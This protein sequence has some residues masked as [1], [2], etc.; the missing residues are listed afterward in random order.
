MKRFTLICIS[1][2]LSLGLL[3]AQTKVVVKKKV[4]SG[5]EHEKVI[6][7]MHEGDMP[8]STENVF[9]IRKAM[10]SYAPVARII[11]KESGFLKKK[12]IVIDF[13]PMSKTITAVRDNGE[14][15]SEA[16]FHKYQEY[17]EDTIELP[18]LEAIEPRMKELEMRISA[19]DGMD[20]VHLVEIEALLEDLEGLDSELALMKKHQLR[21]AKHVIEMDKISE[22]IANLL[23]AE[24]ATPPQKIRE[25]KIEKGK[26]YLNGEEIPGE[27]GEKCIQAFQFQT[28]S[29]METETEGGMQ[30]IDDDMNIHI[31][32]E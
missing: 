7:Q 8:D 30:W 24:G 2:C 27:L 4:H 10:P 15:V 23:E 18:E 14:E 22:A 5:P 11:I 17:L 3:Q 25:I 16:K 31:V 19:L 1:V 26:F 21:S 12:K 9:I 32:V 6:M 13:D 20:S 28:Q 29:G